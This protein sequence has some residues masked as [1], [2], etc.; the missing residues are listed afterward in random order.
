MAPFRDL[1]G[2]RFGRLL[3][4]RENGQNSRKQYKWLCLCDCGKE[5]TKQSWDLVSKKTTSCGCLWEEMSVKGEHHLRHGESHKGKWSPEYRV[6]AAM[7]RR[8]DSPSQRSYRWYGGRGIR[9][10]ERWKTFENFLVD[11]G[12]RP[13]SPPRYTIERE[14]SDGN[15]EPT[16]CRWATYKEQAQT[17]RGCYKPGRHD[18]PIPAGQSA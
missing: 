4:L 6:W 16:N 13:D 3:V 18:R 2:Q 7:L 10:C 14:N 12:R 11:M 9:V 1:T 5:T 17:N 8:C 15:Y